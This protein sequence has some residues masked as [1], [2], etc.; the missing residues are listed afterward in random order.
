MDAQ[1][2]DGRQ[3]WISV[4]HT[5]CLRADFRG[6]GATLLC[7]RQSDR[8]G[9]AGNC[10]KKV[11]NTGQALSSV[12]AVSAGYSAGRKQRAPLRSSPR[13]K[14]LL[15][16]RATAQQGKQRYRIEN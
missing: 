2:K 15:E 5:G 12:W 16:W 3:K 8:T 10:D 4:L 1:V 14:G 11:L 7:G 13:A 6:Y 9:S